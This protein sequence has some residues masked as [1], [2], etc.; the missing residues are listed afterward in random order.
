M[1]VDNFMDWCIRLDMK[2]QDWIP[3][4]KTFYDFLLFIGGF[5][6]MAIMG[7][8]FK[9]PLRQE[10]MWSFGIGFLFLIVDLTSWGDK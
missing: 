9:F 8:F 1:K 5:I 4:H 7:L 3:K 2:Y 10:L 6:L